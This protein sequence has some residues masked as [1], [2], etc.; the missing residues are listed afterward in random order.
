MEGGRGR[1]SPASEPAAVRRARSMLRDLAPL[2]MVAAASAIT[3]G[4]VPRILPLI[5]M[6]WSLSRV[7]S[8][9]VKS[10]FAVGRLGS[11]SGQRPP[12]LDRNASDDGRWNGRVAGRN[13]PVRFGVPVSSVPC[14]AAG[15]G[16]WVR[17]RSSDR[18]G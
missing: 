6:E 9:L 17:D 10:V 1:S 16:H 8:G 3:L 15:D 12:P 4:M 18:L 13:A 11:F 5:G 2:L 7:E 14:R